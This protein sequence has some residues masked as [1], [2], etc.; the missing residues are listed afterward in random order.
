MKWKGLLCA[1]CLLA[2]VSG[3]QAA[4]DTEY[5]H[6]ALTKDMLPVFYPALKQQMTYPMSWLS[7]NFRNFDQWRREA[8]TRLRYALLTPDSHRDF[9]PE[10]L[11]TVDR[12]SYV[13]YKLA[14]NLTDESRVSALML[15]PKTTGKHAAA[16]LLH[17]HGAK[18]DIGKEKMIKP[19]GDEKKL[20]SAQAWS[21]KFFTG[22]FVGDEMAKLG[23]VVIAV[24]ALGWGDR[25]PMAYEKQQALA[26]NFFNLGRS[27]AGNMAYEDMR[28]FD[29]LASRPEVDPE[30]VAIVGFSMGS[31]R[32]WQLA[33][34][35]PQA[36][37]TVADSWM[38]T[39]EGLMT[40]GNNVLRGQSAYYMMHPGLP[41]M[42]DFPDI[43]GIAAPKPML[44]FNGGKDKLFPH[45]AVQQAYQKL[46][47]IWRSQQADERL[48][49]K[50]WPELGHVFYKEQQ[51]EA[52]GWLKQWLH[53]EQVHP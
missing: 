10:V 20:A 44:V 52:F 29:F 46:H 45:A 28:A 49:T 47:Q 18:F 53:P 43:A 16:I 26:S 51:L 21:K 3:I 23:Y 2:G 39:Y 1:A 7:G 25:G 8:R 38:G 13:G 9:Q 6:Q 4:P 31:Y 22:R 37:A 32:A 48:V 14:F 27:L 40:P 36:A 11:D 15:V 5:Q 34:L 12:G 35:R 30:R 41:Q 50:V 33:A 42:M 17:D 19:W 24:D